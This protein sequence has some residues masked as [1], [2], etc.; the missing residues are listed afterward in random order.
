MAREYL[1]VKATACFCAVHDRGL[2][3][4]ALADEPLEHEVV[5]PEGAARSVDLTSLLPRAAPRGSISRGTRDVLGVRHDGSHRIRR[6]RTAATGEADALSVEF[7]NWA[8][9]RATQSAVD[10]GFFSDSGKG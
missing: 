8:S 4:P 3:R 2:V 7:L 10:G 6:Q 9:N 5:K 1:G